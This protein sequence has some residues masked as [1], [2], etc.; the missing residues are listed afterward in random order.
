[1]ALLGWG[2]NRRWV[3]R[4]DDGSRP[5]VVVPK[6]AEI[7]LMEYTREKLDTAHRHSSNHRTELERSEVCGCFYCCETFAAADVE[8]WLEEG[9]GT[10]VCPRCG[11][12]SVIGS[13]SGFPAADR[14]FLDAM[15]QRWFSQSGN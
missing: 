9:S 6:C 13:A 1:M 11:I 3:V 2:R 7:D 10:A 4:W 8:R 15:H 5:L 14:N 12:D